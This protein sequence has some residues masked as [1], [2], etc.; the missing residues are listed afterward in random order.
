MIVDHVLNLICEFIADFIGLIPL[1][2]LEIPA[3]ILNGLSYLLYGLGWFI[4]IQG[5]APILAFSVVLVHIRISIAILKFGLD[6]V[7]AIK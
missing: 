6:V 2:N 7:G 5:I 3:G 1:T 4:P